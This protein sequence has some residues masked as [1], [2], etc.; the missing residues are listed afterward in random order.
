MGEAE[1]RLRRRRCDYLAH[2]FQGLLQLLEPARHFD[3]AVD[4]N[5]RREGHVHSA[6]FADEVL[7]LLYGSD[8]IN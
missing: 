6:V 3:Q 1:A 2:N 7:K 5:Y 8:R 4:A